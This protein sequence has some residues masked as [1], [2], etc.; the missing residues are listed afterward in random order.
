M[1]LA[2]LFR[3]ERSANSMSKE[4]VSVLNEK[5]QCLTFLTR[6]NIMSDFDLYNTKNHGV[7]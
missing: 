1:T 3:G 4:N 7:F 2:N 5:N 6:S